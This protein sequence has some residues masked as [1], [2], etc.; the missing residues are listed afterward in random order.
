MSEPLVKMLTNRGPVR[1]LSIDRGG[2]YM[3]AAGADSR[4]NIFDI[5]TFKEV[6]SYYTPTPASSLHISDTGL[7]SAGWG[8]HV[9][10]WKDALKTRQKSPYLTHLQEGSAINR[11]RFCPFDDTL[12]VGHQGGFSSLIVPGSGEPNFDALEA[13][14]YETA[15][16]RRE[17]EVSALLNKLK[18]EMISLDPNFI[19][20]IDAASKDVRNIEQE[21]RDKERK[22]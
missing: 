22:V 3:A 4:L 14:P 16:Q 15:K 9:T 12:G 18:P 19:G 6:H 10:V 7:L 2:N 8:P 17:R 1:A 20:E 13:N 21:A 5:R 11:V